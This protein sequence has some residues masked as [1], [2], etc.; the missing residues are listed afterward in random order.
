MNEQVNIIENA[1]KVMDESND[2]TSEG[3]TYTTKIA[4]FMKMC[5]SKT[6]EYVYMFVGTY[7]S[8]V[9]ED[10][11]DNIKSETLD[12]QDKEEVEEKKLSN[13]IKTIHIKE[14][15]VICAGWVPVA[16]ELMLHKGI[17]IKIPSIL[18]YLLFAATAVLISGLDIHSNY[19]K[20]KEGGI[21]D[22]ISTENMLLVIEIVAIIVSIASFADAW[23]RK[24]SNVAIDIKKL[25]SIAMM[26]YL[27]RLPRKLMRLKTCDYPLRMITFPIACVAILSI[28]SVAAFASDRFSPY[29]PMICL[30]V[31]TIMLLNNAVRDTE[32]DSDEDNTHDVKKYL[33]Q[34]KH[35]VINVVATILAILTIYGLYKI[36]IDVFSAF[37][38]SSMDFKQEGEYYDL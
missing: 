34:N 12:K 17:F 25:S 37:K 18:M 19:G 16:L 14:I 7:I 9:K 33:K 5:Y 4:G 13:R 22:A 2:N 35:A 8:T 21:W 30:C 24:K 20:L 32:I 28:I 31:S 29:Y 38:T 23:R 11:D 1:N 15:I 6:V 36:N 10:H 3:E 26:I 27:S